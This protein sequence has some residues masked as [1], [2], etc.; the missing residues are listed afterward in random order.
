MSNGIKRREF[1]KVVGVSGAGAGI[2]GCANG[3]V[4]KLLPYVVP[5]D[6]IT[7]G[8]ATW[9]TTVCGE[10]PTGC[11][12]WARTRE[13]RVVKLEGNPRHP[14][15]QGALCQ[16]GH[17]SLQGLY[18]PDRYAGPMLKENGAFRK[19]TWDEAEALLAQRIQGAGGNVML[20]SGH[21]GPTLSGLF[22]AFIAGVGGTRIEYESIADAPL[23]EAAR[24]AFGQDVVPHYDFS[25]ARTIVSFG[26]D[27]LETWLSPV[28]YNRTFSRAS[29][30][31]EG[32]DKARF[33]KVLRAST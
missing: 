11:G 19:A 13:G 32:G 10:C 25:T 15:S 31:K 16:R 6:N 1:L 18:N 17:S 29:V 30:V 23:R 4:E 2:A 21:A 20:V 5:P 8:V 28:E 9:Y 12:V 7:P 24:I 22:D 33:I 3:E 26:A 14:I 27:F